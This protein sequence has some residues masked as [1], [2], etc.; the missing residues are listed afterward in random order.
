MKSFV[1]F[2][3]V[4]LLLLSCKKAE[5]RKCFKSTGDYKID[6]VF[7]PDFGGLVLLHNIEFHLV[8][9]TINYAILKGG[10]NLLNL[11]TF[12]PRDSSI[13]V[14]N[15]NKCN[16]L[17]TY[18]KHIY[19]EIHCKQLNRLEYRGSYPISNSDT[20]HAEIFNFLID[21]GAGTV[22]LTVDANYSNAFIAGGMGDFI[23]KGQAN[24]ATIVIKGHGYCDAS[25]FAVKNA[26]S[27]TNNSKGYLKCFP[28]GAEFNTTITS[29]GNIY[30]HGSPSSII[31]KTTGEGDL[32]KE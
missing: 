30:Y 17:R 7:L 23:L 32:I 25:Q 27:V 29:A 6:T 15:E 16:F 28:D 13:V 22:T 8:P 14:A 26:L 20:L 4:F 18:K 9:D 1:A 5:D 3:I 10:E 24:I 19:V 31:S 2:G 11:V 12:T 21:E